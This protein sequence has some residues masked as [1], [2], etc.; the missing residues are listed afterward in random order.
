MFCQKCGAKVD[1]KFCSSCGQEFT[2]QANPGSAPLVFTQTRDV[3]VTAPGAPTSTMAI[4][5]LIC[6]FFL[7]LV[8]LILGF[9]ARNEINNSR[10]SKSGENLA[11]LAIILGGLFT[12]LYFFFF[13]IYL[14]YGFGY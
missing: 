13:M 5:A 7:P 4:V 11:N 3:M 2:N 9:V 6:A 14:F 8:G 1:G 12:V 10:G